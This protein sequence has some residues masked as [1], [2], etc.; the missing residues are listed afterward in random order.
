M[1]RGT[2]DKKKPRIEC[3]YSVLTALR[4]YATGSLFSVLGD[5]QGMSRM[6]VSRV[7]SDVSTSIANHANEYIIFPNSN[8]E[9]IK[10]MQNYHELSRFPNILGCIDGTH[11]PI[12]TPKQ[13]E[14]LYV[15][16]KNFHSINVQGVCDS[17]L[18]FTNLVAKWPG[19]SHDSFIWTDSA[20]SLKFESGE[21][22][23]GWLLGDSAYPLRPWM[24][25]PYLQPSTPSEFRYNTRHMKARNTIERCFGVWKGRFR[26]LDKSGGP[27]LFDPTK[28]CK[29]CCTI[30][31]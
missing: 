10:V 8:A 11:V 29:L 28:A 6:I 5:A 9:K 7:I 30:C 16:R 26:C 31:A 17:D 18:R 2:S 1:R 23:E 4:Y 25:T 12:R 14:H 3:L 24:L 19:S 21:I 22:G 15:N 27:V 20:L 13:D